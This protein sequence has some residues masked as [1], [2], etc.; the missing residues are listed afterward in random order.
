MAWE[1]NYSIGRARDDISYAVWVNYPPVEGLLK[2]QLTK[3]DVLNHTSI[4]VECL[5][6][7]HAH[8]VS[9]FGSI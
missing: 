2:I 4:Q 3:S 8:V 7:I 5:V 9:F 6:L 1:L